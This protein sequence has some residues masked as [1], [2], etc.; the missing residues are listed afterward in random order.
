MG[1]SFLDAYDENEEE[2]WGEV[3]WTRMTRMKT[4]GE[5]FSDSE[6]NDIAD[7]LDG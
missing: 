2:E 6:G 4:R 7:A 3:E 5:R 1:E